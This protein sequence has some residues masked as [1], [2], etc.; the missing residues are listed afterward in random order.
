MTINQQVVSPRVSRQLSQRSVFEVLL[1]KGPISRADLSKVT[2][3]SKQTT[4]EV[5]DAFEQQGLVRPMGRTSGNVGRTAVLYELSPDGGYCLGVDLGGTKVTAAIAD[6]S[7]KVLSEATEST[8]PRGGVAVLDQIARLAGRLARDVGA[9]PSRIRS[10]VIGTP[11]VVDVRS[12]A[13]DLAPNIAHLGELDVV[14]AISEKLGRPV[15][16]ENDVNLGLL[17]EI[18]HGCA[19]NVA[20]VA[21][22]ALGTGIGLGIYANGRLVRGENGAAGEIGYFPIGGDPWRAEVR[23]QGCLEYEAGAI[24]IVRRYNQAGGSEVDGVLPIFERMKRGEVLAEKI[25]GETARL[26]AQAVSIVAVTIDPKLVVLGGSIGAR[27][28]FAQR[29]SEQSSLLGPRPVEIRP[30]ALGNRASVVGA[31]A[32]AL[33]RFHE[34][35]F[36]I[37]EFPGTFALPAP[38]AETER[39]RG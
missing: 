8:D 24:G 15:A 18:W 7:S 25:I 3:L 29:V 22:I 4:S 34:D 27:P 38:K 17:G 5:I 19:Q 26:I 16:V 12:G 30:S 2:G 39:M 33:N 1:Q 23:E 6:I 14:G 10:I 32:V 21:F 36:G 11:G 20:D 9:H 31:L 28:E 35:L 13:I 37:A